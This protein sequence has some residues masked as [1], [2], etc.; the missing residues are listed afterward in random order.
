MQ[1]VPTVQIAEIR[2]DKHRTETA[3]D[4]CRNQ[5]LP[6]SGILD[7]QHQE[8]ETENEQ[9]RGHNCPTVEFNNPET[10]E[11][12]VNREEK[13]RRSPKSLAP[14]IVEE[15]TD[16]KPATEQRRGRPEDAAETDF[17]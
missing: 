7:E 3:K 2:Q 6:R 10:P 4:H 11:E 16:N 12:K 14:L 1:H 9:C 8:S 17:N 15:R 13:Q 5:Y